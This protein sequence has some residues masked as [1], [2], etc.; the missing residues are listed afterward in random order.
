MKIDKSA[1][2][3]AAQKNPVYMTCDLA[4]IYMY[5]YQFKEIY[6]PVL[7]S[8]SELSSTSS[9]KSSSLS[10]TSDLSPLKSKK[11]THDFDK[12]EFQHIFY[13]LMAT[14]DGFLK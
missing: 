12:N 2:Y 13:V 5:M 10:I 4:Y 9:I 7:I 6:V 1:T 11:I 8:S 14:T 3:Y